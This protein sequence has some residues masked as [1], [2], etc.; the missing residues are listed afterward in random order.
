MSNSFTTMH[1]GLIST[2]NYINVSKL[3]VQ[4]LLLKRLALPKLS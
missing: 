2:S 1:S 4:R 3:G